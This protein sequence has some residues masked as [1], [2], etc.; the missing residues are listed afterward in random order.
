MLVLP[1]PCITIYQSFLILILLR[2]AI[3]TLFGDSLHAFI[4]PYSPRP[5]FLSRL[6]TLTPKTSN[7]ISLLMM[8][9]VKRF[10]IP[11]EYKTSS[12]L[13]YNNTHCEKAFLPTPTYVLSAE[14]HPHY[15]PRSGCSFDQFLS[16]RSTL[17][18]AVDRPNQQ[19]A[20]F[21]TS[22]H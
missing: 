21:R 3:F 19:Y 8:S 4:T 14:R 2:T 16:H 15:V 1:N 20:L 6:S 10:L 12:F 18:P 22:S 7:T 11:F 13:S 9:R 17:T 5:F